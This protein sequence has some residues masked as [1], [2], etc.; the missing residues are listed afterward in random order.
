MV[1]GWCLMPMDETLCNTVFEGVADWNDSTSTCFLGEYA[2]EGSW[3][4]TADEVCMTAEVT[5]GDL[6][7]WM[8]SAAT[9]CF[10]YEVA[11]TSLVLTAKEE[12]SPMYPL[13]T[14]L[15]LSFGKLPDSME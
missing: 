8:P 1:D 7:D 6:P 14:C 15:S 10:G 11:G 3:E 5:E 13:G 9:K 4:I 12:A 2:M